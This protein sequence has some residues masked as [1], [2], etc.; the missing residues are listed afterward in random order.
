MSSAATCLTFIGLL[1]TLI[2]STLLFFNSVS[3]KQIGNTIFDGDQVQQFEAD[4]EHREVPESEWRPIA[5]RLRKQT[6]I[7]NS[8]GFGLVA[9][10]TL[11]QMIALHI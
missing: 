7:L 3:K 1:L 5:D 2:G 6:K 10:G 11:L 9:L 4:S 8:V